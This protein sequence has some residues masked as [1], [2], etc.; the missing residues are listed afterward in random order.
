MKK[1]VSTVML[2][3]LASLFV[4]SQ[5]VQA[6][7]QSAQ[8]EA[9]KQAL[10]GGSGAAAPVKKGVRTRAIVFDEG[11]A[12]TAASAQSAVTGAASAVASAAGSGGCAGLSPGTKTTPV[13]FTIEFKVGSAQLAP[14]SENTLQQIGKLLSLTPDRCVIVE[15]HTDSSGN[16][17][18]NLALSQARADSVVKFLTERQNLGRERLIAKGKGSTEPASGLAPTDPKNRRVVFK[19]AG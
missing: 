8:L 16:A 6:D 4:L 14:A 19:V 1:Q 3:L 13:A 17:D 15:G 7:D 2:G 11:D 18:K 5:P 9:L 10:Q 12:G